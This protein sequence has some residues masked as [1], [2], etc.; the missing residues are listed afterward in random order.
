MSQENVEVVRRS[1]DAF[2]RGNRDGVRETL[3]PEYETCGL[4]ADLVDSGQALPATI[5]Q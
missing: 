3:A 4:R 5:D 2:S 1:I